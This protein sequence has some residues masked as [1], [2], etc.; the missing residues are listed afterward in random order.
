M[1]QNLAGKT[2][3]NVVTIDAAQVPEEVKEG[4]GNAKRTEIS[5]NTE[6]FL[7]RKGRNNSRVY[8]VGDES[9]GEGLLVPTEALSEPTPYVDPNAAPEAE[10]TAE[11]SDSATAESTE[12]TPAEPVAAS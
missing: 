4:S 3:S 11:A 10:E 8:K 2:Y 1:A 12:D 5:A 6:Y 7:V 9:P